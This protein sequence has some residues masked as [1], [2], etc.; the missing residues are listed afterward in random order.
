MKE[1]LRLHRL[2]FGMLVTLLILFVIFLMRLHPGLA[3]EH[4]EV[5]TSLAVVVLA[6][7]VFL[8][9]GSMEGAIAFQFGKKHRRELFTYLLLAALSLACGLYLTLSDSATIQTVA[10]V[11]APHALLFGLVELR[12]SRHLDR[13]APY[14]RALIFCGVI[15]VFLALVLVAG[16]WL[17]SRETAALLSYVAILSIIQLLPLVFYRHKTTPSHAVPWETHP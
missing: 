4:L 15:E 12:L 6:A 10:L 8:V 13:H 2:T 14:R 1:E 3:Q 17:S 9:M 16:A 5:A 11:A 7:A